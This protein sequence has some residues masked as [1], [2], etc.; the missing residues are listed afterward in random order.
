[1][2]LV[3]VGLE[4]DRVPL[5]LLERV[6]VSE[7]DLGKVLV[8]LAEAAEVTEVAVVSTC[9]R[10]EV[11]A[12]VDRFHDGV[13]HLQRFLA[14]RAGLDLGQLAERM[15]VGFDDQV[16]DHLFRVAAGLRSAVLGESEVLGQVRR[17][18]EQAVAA[19]AA[20]PV[21]RELF[22]RA[23]LA[24][25]RVRSETAIGRGS[26]SLS[27]VAAELVAEQ[28]GGTLAG[29][30]AL[31]VG[32]GEMGQGVTRAL[33]T[34]GARVQV[35][36]RT[37]A[38]AEALVAEVGAA[39][40]LGLGGLRRALPSAEVVAVCTAGGVP[41]LEASALEALRRGA[42]AP[43]VV[44]DLGMPRA[45][46]RAVG[47]LPGVQLFDLE[48]LRA[49]AQEALGGRLAEVANAEAVVAEE[50]ARYRAEQRARG[51]APVVAALR[52]Q[53]EGWQEEALARARRRH[54]DLTDEQ[55]A[56]V[57]TVSRDLVARLLHQPSVAL[58]EAAGTSRGE[59]LV[60]AARALFGL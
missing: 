30:S 47:Q 6:A 51:A 31:V 17:A 33:V 55:W 19:Q 5:D 42:R 12:V 58:K 4:P 22:R 38:R 15:T 1:V 41:V 49:R 14:E 36:N 7:D 9:L 27:H 13:G 10:T 34:A 59:R 29:R 44:V 28:L 11:Y 32:A 23:V 8:D 24:G 26:L 53:V 57:A 37:L 40:A 56:A 39:G 46:E 43:L 20:G 54:P 3:V 18:G 60:E 35:A 2:S 52:R 48:D 50:L 25:R 45:V 21:L 16:A